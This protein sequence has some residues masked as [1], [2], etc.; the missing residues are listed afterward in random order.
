MAPS[1][2]SLL[3]IFFAGYITRT[4]HPVHGQGGAVRE[5]VPRLVVHRAR[6]LP[7]RAWTAPTAPRCAHRQ[8]A[9]EGG[10]PVAIFPEGTR[11]HGR[12]IVELFDGGAYLAIRLGVP[13]VPVGIGG[14][15]EIL[16]SGKTLPR[17]AQG[18]GRRRRADPAARPRRR[19][20]P[21][22]GGRPT[23]TREGPR[24]AADVLR[25]G[26]RARRRAGR[27]ASAALSGRG[28]R[29]RQ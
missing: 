20:R 4:P 2:R 8:A 3:D 6:R 27:P 28:R 9:L 26:A 10:E 23:L 12:E 11:R 19:A 25:R 13:I 14:S 16:A 21:A 1:H 5:A 15:E 18:G 24:G 22:S 17:L 7:G 29:A